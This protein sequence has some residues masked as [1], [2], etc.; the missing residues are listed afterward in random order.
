MAGV[1]IKYKGISI[2]TIQGTGS[3]TLKTEGKYCEGDIVVDYTKE[4]ITPSGTKN[5]T[6]NGTHD[7]TQYASANV[8]VPTGI[9]PSG[10]INI[11]ANGTYDVTDKA[12]AVVAVQ[13]GSQNSKCFK[14][15]FES[16]ITT[17]GWI[18][19][20]EAD[21][22]I[23]AH[24][25]D[26]TFV[27]TI[28]NIT[29]FSV[30]AERNIAVTATNHITNSFNSNYS[31]G[32]LLKAANNG[33]TGYGGVNKAVNVST[34]A[35]GGSQICVTSDGKIGIYNSAYTSWEAGTYVALCGW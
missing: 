29:D 30:A 8:N 2:A 32:M 22:D 13:T 7:V 18:Y 17:N 4:G 3:K 35:S 33:V 27:V 26:P 20:N 31:Y 6:S 1:D 5:I 11:T 14:K 12:S 21:T 9:T 23:A 19:F 16:K 34:P 10:S 28:M 15:T 25:N 24:I